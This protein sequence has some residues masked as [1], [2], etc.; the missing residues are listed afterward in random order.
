MEK[1]NCPP[2]KH[3]LLEH[4]SEILTE[5]L[6]EPCR[7]GL[8]SID[9]DG[10][11]GRGLFSYVQLII[12]T[13]HWE[14]TALPIDTRYHSKGCG[15]CLMYVLWAKRSTMA[16]IRSLSPKRGGMAPYNCCFFQQPK[17]N[18]TKNKNSPNHP[19][20]FFGFRTQE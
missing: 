6:H 14:K 2:L 5:I 15:A 1:S 7:P 13:D 12:G 11:N 18:K 3:D 9:C 16:Q 19:L 8:K 10:S 20:Q 4:C 17:K